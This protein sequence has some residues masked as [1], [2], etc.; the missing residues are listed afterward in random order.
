MIRGHLGG[1]GLP[2]QRRKRVTRFWGFGRLVLVGLGIRF[3]LLIHSG[4]S[5]RA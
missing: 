1:G 4:E 5:F 3:F 2:I